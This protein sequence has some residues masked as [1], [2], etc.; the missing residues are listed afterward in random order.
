MNVPFIIHNTESN[1]TAFTGCTL[2]EQPNAVT[3]DN[4]PEKQF[5]SGKIQIRA[6]KRET[7]ELYRGHVKDVAE[8]CD[9][10]GY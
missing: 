5:S 2:C 6:T 9:R 10:S 7:G 3:N 8:Y 1:F 4:G